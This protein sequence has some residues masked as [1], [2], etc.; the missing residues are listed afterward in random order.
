MSLTPLTHIAPLAVD[1]PA[2][3]GFINWGAITGELKGALAVCVF[4]G[5][6]FIAIQIARGN[7]SAFVRII[8]CALMGIFAVGLMFLISNPDTA[9][10]LVS[11]FIN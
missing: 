7:T 5:A 9:Q 11:R 8:A 10:N 4:I 3:G 2:E 1:Q 6:I